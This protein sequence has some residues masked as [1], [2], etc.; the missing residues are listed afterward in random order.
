[1]VH[2]L[3]SSKL[4][5]RWLSSLLEKVKRHSLLQKLLV[6]L[7]FSA[8]K[9][10]NQLL[11]F[12]GAGLSAESGIAT[13]RDNEDG[14]WTKYDP[15]EVCN[16]RT[17]AKNRELVFKF[18]NE[19]RAQLPSLKPNAAHYG[20]AA[21]QKQYGKDRVK[22]FTQ[23]IDD[24]LERAGCE[25]VVH[26]HGK[27]TDL[28]CLKCGHVWDVGYEVMHMN[29]E[30]VNCGE[31]GFLKPGVVFFGEN[32]PNYPLL[33]ST[34]KKARNDVILVIGTAGEVVPLEYIVGNQYSPNKP[35]SI[36]CNKDFDR[37]GPIPYHDFDVCMFKPATEAIVQ[38]SLIVEKK[39]DEF[40]VKTAAQVS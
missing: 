28:Q 40:A 31:V 6:D 13:F 30:C 34:F 19:R 14:L 4:K 24:F 25:D 18:Y 38:L 36:L 27:F 1:M 23:N 17:F 15:D 16:L 7:K 29:D 3:R 35:F 2:T 5:P 12:T 9:N 26:V 32:A 21:L 20:L 37:G 8:D 10:M 39:M 11:I 22:I 33:Y